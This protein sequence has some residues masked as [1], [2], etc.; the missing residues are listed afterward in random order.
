MIKS[1][2]EEHLKE[3]IEKVIPLLS[4]GEGESTIN[5]EKLI[6]ILGCLMSKCPIKRALQIDALLQRR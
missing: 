5:L 3:I 4:S 1:I 6:E 2:I